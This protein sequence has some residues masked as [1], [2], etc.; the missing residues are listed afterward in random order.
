[1]SL[2]SFPK[3]NSAVLCSPEKGCG[4]AASLVGA[5]QLASGKQPVTFSFDAFHQN[6]LGP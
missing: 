1:M 3:V 2:L 4:T 5:L 6:C